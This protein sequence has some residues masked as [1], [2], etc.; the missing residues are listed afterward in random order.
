M[1]D[2]FCNDLAAGRHEIY[3]PFLTITGN[4]SQDNIFKIIYLLRVQANLLFY[5]HKNYILCFLRLSLK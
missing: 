3:S 2:N 4:L 5:Q 1:K